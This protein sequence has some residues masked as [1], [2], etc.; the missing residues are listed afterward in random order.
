MISKDE[1][2][3][4]IHD[5][6]SKIELWCKNNPEKLP[7][8]KLKQ[9][10]TKWNKEIINAN[11]LADKNDPLFEKNDF[12]VVYTFMNIATATRASHVVANIYIKKL[13]NEL[14]KMKTDV[15]SKSHC[16]DN[17]IL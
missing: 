17:K 13:E 9:E 15:K 12:G 5:R 7:L 10:L 14:K 4:I 2:V 8:K 3:K 11:I 1:I 6:E 16:L